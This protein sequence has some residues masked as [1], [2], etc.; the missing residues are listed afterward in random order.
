[1]IKETGHGPK[2][3]IWSI[4]AT[5]FEMATGS[6]PWSKLKPYAAMYSIA[7]GDTDPPVLPDNFSEE[8]RDF[9]RKCLTRDENKRPDA[10]DLLNHNFLS[11]S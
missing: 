3:D 7:Q 10:N 2:A 11:V 4:G 1:V 9:C 5:V 8:A 6:P